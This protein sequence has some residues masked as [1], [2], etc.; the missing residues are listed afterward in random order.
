[1]AR[2][3][4]G[5]ENE[6]VSQLGIDAIVA[7]GA[8]RAEDGTQNGAV[9]V[10]FGAS[11]QQSAIDGGDAHVDADN[12]GSGGGATGASSGDSSAGDTSAGAMGDGDGH[13][14]RDSG[15][16]AMAGDGAAAVRGDR[17]AGPDN[18]VGESAQA[19]VS[20]DA[21]Q[22]EAVDLVT[23]MMTDATAQIPLLDALDRSAS[24]PL[25]EVVAPPS[26][27]QASDASY[28]RPER[29]PVAQAGVP[30]IVGPGLRLD[31]DT[32]TC[33][34]CGKKCDGVDGMR[35]HRYKAHPGWVIEPG[36][37]K[38]RK[39]ETQKPENQAPETA[40]VRPDKPADTKATDG[41]K[42][43]EELLEFDAV[44][45]L[46]STV[47]AML[48]PPLA[49]WEKDLIRKA[50]VKI[51]V[52]RWV[53]Q[54]LVIG[55]VI[56]PR[57]KSNWPKIRETW[58]KRRAE[59]QQRLD[60]KRAAASAPA[61]TPAPTP[62]IAAARVHTSHVAEPAPAPAPRVAMVAADSYPDLP[63]PRGP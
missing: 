29:R 41:P 34:C 28:M 58:Q 39:P 15:V 43:P 59:V 25:F 12:G 55:I 32:E 63:E 23:G 17:H 27:G 31:T 26:S 57:V 54:M 11:A 40:T 24:G 22:Q 7:G 10:D 4:K 18:R 42:V 6:H 50:G 35:K 20:Q 48:P 37:Q 46:D 44:M 14:A 3:R 52:P 38:G 45:L 61:P 47:C 51:K 1:M 56:V 53:Y 21:D 13:G 2:Q 8:E 60:A 19:P 49:D 36:G 33:V 5:G 16:A 30:V 9:E 62:A